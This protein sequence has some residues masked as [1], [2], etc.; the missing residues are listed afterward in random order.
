MAGTDGTGKA[1]TPNTLGG[2][3]TPGGAAGGGRRGGGRRRESLTSALLQLAVV[4]VVL[5]GAVAFYVH[6]GHA[7]ARVH[8]KVKEAR[9]VAVKGNPADLRRALALVDEALAVRDDHPDALSV[10]ADVAT[11][12]WLTHREEGAEA[13]AKELLAAAVAA[14]ARSEERY[15]TEA[16]H[17][18]AA[19]D[20]AGAAA[21]VEDLTN[22][23]A[24]RPRI[25][26]AAARARQAL[27]QLPLA[28]E[29]YRLA[30]EAAWRDPR[31]AVGMAELFLEED[32]P[33]RAAELLD[34]ALHANPEHL[35][36]KLD[37]ALV[38]TWQ[39]AD[40]A[41]AG[42]MVDEVLARPE[43]ELSSSLRA[44]AHA[45]K[46]E[47]A[48][49]D[50]RAEQAQAAADEALKLRA[51]EPY[52]LYARARALAA[53]K[54]PRAAEAFQAAV[55]GRKTAPVLYFGGAE[56]LSRAGNL[57]GARALLDGYE[58]TFRDVKLATTDG[59]EQPFLERDDRYWLARGDLLRDT[60]DGDGALK[61]YDSAINARGI[62]QARAHYAKAAVLLG[63]K[64][65]A[66]AKEL[67]VKAAPQ[68]G[69]GG[70]LEAY[71][72][73]GEVLFSEKDYA[74]ACANYGLALGRMRA[75]GVP[76]ERMVALSEDVNKRLLAVGQGPLAAEWRKAAAA[77]L[78]Q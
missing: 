51:D 6:R 12:L 78:K 34:K 65:Y 25:W 22:Q 58:A 9:A 42:A 72:A 68:D 18:L 30:A 11:E 20:A 75:T 15:A 62:N 63:R 37:M 7:R 71:V 39:R 32:Q 26:Y 55:T 35:Q 59:K 48:L 21:F 57:P 64:D 31:F 67:L 29:A 73:M 13:R 8:E 40:V 3:G 45:V 28:R 60:G 53:R 43:P 24:N 5:A 41:R 77:T 2:P 14:D 10:G 1:S 52:A 70:I 17:T 16:L 47:L 36:A 66:K 56:A 33:L 38:R 23:G 54:D 46:A 50:G 74:H 61:A 76:R 69:N 49:A 19:G 4:A 44:R 27:G